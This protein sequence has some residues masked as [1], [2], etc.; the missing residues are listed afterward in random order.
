MQK[1]IENPKEAIIEHYC[2]GCKKLIIISGI[3]EDAQPETGLQISLVLRADFGYNSSM[4]GLVFDHIYCDECAMRL[5]KLI[6]KE[7]N[8]KI[9][10]QIFK[11]LSQQE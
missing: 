4:V 1:I 7:F 6:E 10:T 11:D 8:I 5:V 2:D 9:E 3:S